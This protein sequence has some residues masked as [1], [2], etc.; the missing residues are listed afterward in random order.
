MKKKFSLFEELETNIETIN[1]IDDCIKITLGPTG[2]NGIVSNEKGEIK[3]I[4]SGSI[5]L[6]SLEFKKNSS[7]VILKLLEQ[8]SAKTYKVSGDGST[9]TTLISCQLLKSSLRFLTNGYNP[10]FISNGL[11]KLA[12]FVVEKALELSIPVEN[13]K[14]LSG[15]LRT[16]LGK[17]INTELFTVLQKCISSFYRDGLI[18]VEE[19]IR[20]ENEIEIVQ[21]IELD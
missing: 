20:P 5:L 7:N 13:E 4:T 9:T 11:K 16:S 21:G 14:Q 2:K 1:E 6:N 19:N 18:L 17:K 10:I 8:A 12:Y 15:L 3:F